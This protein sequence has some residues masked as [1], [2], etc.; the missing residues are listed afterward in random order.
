MFTFI[1]WSLI[2]TTQQCWM[3]FFF[4]SFIHFKL[5]WQS[6]WNGHWLF[7][8]IVTIITS[9]MQFSKPIMRKARFFSFYKYFYRF[10]NI[11]DWFQPAKLGDS[12]IIW[13]LSA[14]SMYT[15][16]NMY[17]YSALPAFCHG[18]QRKTIITTAQKA[19]KICS[20]GTKKWN[21]W[22]IYDWL[23]IVCTMQCVCMHILFDYLYFR[24]LLFTH[25]TQTH[26]RSIQTK[27]WW[28]VVCNSNATDMIFRCDSLAE[29]MWCA[30][31]CAFHS[32]YK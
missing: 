17:T 26:T 20:I 29:C 10:L 22:A 19:N 7:A 25:K 30:C 13:L 23:A 11:V 21:K 6:R 18:K 28:H 8:G 14:N 1:T 24:L 15:L 32:W 4:Q 3:E 2:N 31:V 5:Y 27:I 12:R 16:R 9:I